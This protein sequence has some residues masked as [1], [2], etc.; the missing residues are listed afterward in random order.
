MF[1]SQ[2]S[3]GFMWVFTIAILLYSSE[4]QQ[5]NSMVRIFEKNLDERIAEK[6]GW[7]A[8]SPSS[9]EIAGDD[10]QERCLSFQLS[11]QIALF[12]A[13]VT[14]IQQKTAKEYGH[15]LIVEED[16]TLHDVPTVGEYFQVCLP[17]SLTFIISHY[18]TCEM[19]IWSH[20][21]YLTPKDHRD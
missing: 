5:A 16:W 10:V 13:K 19:F 2:V 3:F 7:L 12:G 1:I 14:C 20:R 4:T 15:S 9:W 21:S 17:L 8:Y 18:S 11:N 6:V